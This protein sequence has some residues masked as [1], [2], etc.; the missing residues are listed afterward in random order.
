MALNRHSMVL[1][2]IN[3]LDVV[4]ISPWHRVPMSWSKHSCRY[5]S[6]FDIFFFGK[7]EDRT[8]IVYR[9]SRR[10]ERTKEEDNIW[11]CDWS[12]L[13]PYYRPIQV[14]IKY[15]SSTMAMVQP[16]A[17]LRFEGY[18]QACT[19]ID[20]IYTYTHIHSQHCHQN[21]ALF[22]PSFFLSFVF[23]CTNWATNN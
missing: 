6:F 22:P 12:H 4:F 20:Y 3:A 21:F 5:Y 1:I 2:Y 7:G 17:T 8:T 18:K 9:R 14:V 15:R 13:I 23:P 19:Y 11:H 10:P 16:F